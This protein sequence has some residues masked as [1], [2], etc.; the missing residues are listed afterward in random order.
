MN[1]GFMFKAFGA[2]LVVGVILWLGFMAGGSFATGIANETQL[3]QIEQCL[4][5]ST[6]DEIKLCLQGQR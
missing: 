5:A 3:E 1:F 2:L 6:V 4:P